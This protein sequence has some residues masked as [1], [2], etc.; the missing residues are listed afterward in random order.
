MSTGLDVYIAHVNYGD[1]I[2]WQGTTTEE[3]LGTQGQAT[4]VVQD[5]TNSL[6]I[7]EH[8]DI[9]LVVHDSGWVLFRGEVIT[10]KGDLPVGMPWTRYTLSCADY[11]G[12]LSQRLVGA[13]DGNTWVR[14][15]TR[16]S[17]T[18]TPID[19]YRQ[20]ASARIA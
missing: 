2:E 3:I 18:Y 17:A 1:I 5:R 12:E 10:A 8:D 4:I 13:V 19:P 6:V 11:N 7:N 20:H 9:K 15:S 14:G 16:R